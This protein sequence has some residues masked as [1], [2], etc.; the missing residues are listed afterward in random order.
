MLTLAHIPYTV[1]GHTGL[2]LYEG[3]IMGRDPLLGER[4]DWV[5]NDLLA[6]EEGK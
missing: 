5:L 1:E 6:T 4:T 2:H 3:K